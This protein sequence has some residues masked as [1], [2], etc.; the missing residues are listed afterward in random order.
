ML[1]IMQKKISMLILK[2]YHLISKS[3]YLKKRAYAI[4]SI[5]C[6][7]V[8]LIL[9][10]S[11]EYRSAEKSLLTMQPDTKVTKLSPRWVL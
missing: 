5:G 4:I 7:N 8:W 11:K 1:I 10:I 9:S 6:S 2:L 3:K